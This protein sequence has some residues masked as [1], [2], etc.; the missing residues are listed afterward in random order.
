MPTHVPSQEI[1]NVCPL[2]RSERQLFQG[3]ELATVVFHSQGPS[4]AIE[5]SDLGVHVAY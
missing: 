2:N 4:K 5:S 3:I 1:G